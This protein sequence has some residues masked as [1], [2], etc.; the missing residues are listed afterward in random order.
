MDVSFDFDNTLSKLDVQDFARFCMNKKLVVWIITARNGGLYDTYNKDLY[1]VVNKLN[2]NPN[3]VVFMNHVDKYRFLEDTNFLF[4][5][6]DDFLEVEL[7]N[8]NTNILGVYKHS[9]VD[10]EEVCFNRIKNLI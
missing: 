1:N 9:S 5:L 4:H 8:E 10:W 3:N 7:I 2:I 6:D